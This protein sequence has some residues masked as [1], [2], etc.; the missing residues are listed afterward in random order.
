MAKKKRQRS[1]TRQERILK[2]QADSTFE[3]RTRPVPGAKED[4][5]AK[6]RDERQEYRP[7]VLTHAI[8]LTGIVPIALLIV[9]LIAHVLWPWRI[10]HWFQPIADKDVAVLTL[11]A[12]HAGIIGVL[13]SS[14][15]RFTASRFPLIIAAIATAAAGFRT[16][17]ESTPG[18][19]IA[20]MLFL[21]TVPAVWAE[22]LNANMKRFWAFARSR[23][24]ILTF[25][26]A[27][28]VV[29]T[30]YYQGRDE[31]YIKNW[32]L[33][34]LGIVA[35]I[36]VAIFVLWLLIGLSYKYVPSMFSWLR[37]RLSATYRRK[38]RRR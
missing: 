36:V 4:A 14:R 18:V 20:L 15:G 37:S 21:L 10:P 1:R 16:I 26:V 9:S 31:N 34:P 28:A 3:S 12:G 2:R 32:I 6:M 11:S 19:V 17:G 23:K 25:L 8:R 27:I 22:A 7:S 5:D 38:V 29:L 30:A 13:L 33:I 24:G 35:G